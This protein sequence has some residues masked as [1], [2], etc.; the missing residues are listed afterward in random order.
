[1]HSKNWLPFQLG[2]D[3]SLSGKKTLSTQQ[4]EVEWGL[5][6]RKEIIYRVSIF[7]YLYS[8]C[9][10]K[11]HT[12]LGGKLEIIKASWF[13]IILFAVI[14]WALLPYTQSK[15]NGISKQK[16]KKRQN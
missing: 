4:H 15:I 8:V 7:Y 11:G 10:Y 3:D 1:M 5:A 6:A 16:Y 13:L 14:T 12:N 2:R 9:G